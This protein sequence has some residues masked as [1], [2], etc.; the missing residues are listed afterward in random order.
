M[1]AKKHKKLQLSRETL[2]LLR[3]DQLSKVNGGTVTL[4][5]HECNIVAPTEDWHCTVFS[6]RVTQCAGC[7]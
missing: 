4:P 7:G 1:L 5:G 2:R 3:P 6:N